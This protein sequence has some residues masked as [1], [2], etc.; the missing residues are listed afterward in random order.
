MNRY[1]EKASNESPGILQVLTLILSIYVLAALFVQAV[2]PLSP[3]TELLLEWIDFAICFVFLGDFFLRLCQAP[4]KRNF[5]KWGW[6]DLLSSIPNFDILRVGR[7]VGLI[8]LFRL[9]RAFRST[10]ALVDYL[11]GNRAKSTFSTVAAV[12]LL[13]TMFASI[14]MLHL[15]KGAESNIKTPVDALWWAIA[16][17]TTVGY[18]DKFPVTTEGR[19][20]AALLMTAG[21]GLF[22]TFTA[23]V[24]R[25]FV[26]SDFGKEESELQQVLGEVRALRSQVASL[27]AKLDRMT[28][29]VDPG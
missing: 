22:G 25:A 13:L 15:E 5:L 17:I 11:F 9:L 21:V 4:S 24:A 16:T 27:E 18:G 14:A 12:S 23:F 10:K 29:S 1:K 3:D 28:G 19:A 20:V 2:F 8:R 6:I 26:A 7:A